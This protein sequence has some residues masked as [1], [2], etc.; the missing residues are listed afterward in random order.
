[1]PPSDESLLLL[2]LGMKERK[3]AIR[4][5]PGLSGVPLVSLLQL[6]PKSLLNVLLSPDGGPAADASAALAAAG[7]STSMPAAAARASA[8]AATC[9]PLRR[10]SLPLRLA[11]ADDGP[12]LLPDA[13][14]AGAGRLRLATLFSSCA[15]CAL[16][17]GLSGAGAGPCR[18]LAAAS[19]LAADH[20]QCCRRCC[21]C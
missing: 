5:L 9:E 6:A 7:L 20:K 18:L 12:P 1:M 15:T 2:V 4:L 21:C 8:C 14:L 10:T 13:R 11:P 19:V 16:R 17:V 3:A